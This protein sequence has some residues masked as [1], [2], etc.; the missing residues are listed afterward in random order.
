[1]HE[2]NVNTTW[3]WRKVVEQGVD[4]VTFDYE[5][6]LAWDAVE[7]ATYTAVVNATTMA[8]HAAVPRSQ[9]ALVCRE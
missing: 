7:V 3:I 1:M 6:P 5:S 8:V 9:V 2:N 4:G